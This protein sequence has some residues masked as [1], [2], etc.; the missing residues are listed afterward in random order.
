LQHGALGSRFVIHALEPC[1]I[2]ALVN[3]TGIFIPH[4]VAITSMLLG[5]S[6]HH[7]CDAFVLFFRMDAFLKGDGACFA[8]GLKVLGKAWNLPK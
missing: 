1:H 3:S 6:H 5:V 7:A 2:M 8:P 4:L